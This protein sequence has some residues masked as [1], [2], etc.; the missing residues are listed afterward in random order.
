MK[1][2]ELLGLA[3]AFSLVGWAQ[4]Q[5]PVQGQ[6]PQQQ[7]Q[8][9]T[10]T[11]GQT[12]YPQGQSTQGQTQGQMPTQTQDPSQLPGRTTPPPEEQAP[13]QTQSPSQTQPGTGPG[14][15]SPAPST[16]PTEG[17]AA[18]QTPPGQTPTQPTEGTMPGTAS[19]APS[20]SPTEGTA[21]D[22]TPPGETPVR[23]A[24]SEQQTTRMATAGT[25]TSSAQPMHIIG[26]DVKSLDG[27]TIG[28][29]KD[30]I[31]EPQ[32]GTITHVLVAHG[33][34]ASAGPPHGQ[35]MHG[36]PHD[37]VAPGQ[38]PRGQGQ[39]QMP[40]SQQMLTA[41]PWSS[42]SKMMQG[43]SFVMDE[44]R[45]Q[46]APSFTEQELSGMGGSTALSEADRY[47]S[48]QGS[49]RSA[50]APSTESGSQQQGT[51]TQPPQG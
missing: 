18:D 46:G 10:T 25:T 19:P 1:K 33:P 20:T 41:V 47:W 44:T 16:S 5:Q 42:V 22:R 37:Q 40:S 31:V 38:L 3:A 7:G 45:L 11:P 17:T 27:T 30:I 24:T 50:T 15:T 6:S 23:G 28:K 36:Q 35:M 2:L 39:Q 26:R 29:V 13:S 4:A 48:G 14:T 21:A 51:T 43:D 34:Q 32:S 9:Q 12:T 8:S 49:S